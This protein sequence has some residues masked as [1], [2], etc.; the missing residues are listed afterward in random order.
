MN[1]DIGTHA[2]ANSLNCVTAFL[3]NGDTAITDACVTACKQIVNSTPE[4]RTAL[5]SLLIHLPL[6]QESTLAVWE[7]ALGRLCTDWIE[8]REYSKIAE[9]LTHSD[10][11]IRTTPHFVW[12]DGSAFTINHG[13]RVASCCTLLHI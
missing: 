3:D 1:L 13:R 8:A 10:P 12:L 4:N 9:L 11:R 6:N 2:R 7:Y 5:H